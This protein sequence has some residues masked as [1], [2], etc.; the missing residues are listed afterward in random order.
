MFVTFGRFVEDKS[1]YFLLPVISTTLRASCNV[2]RLLEFNPVT[3]ILYG[4]LVVVSGLLESHV[5]R[6]FMETS[7]AETTVMV[8]NL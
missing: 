5:L 6:L 3:L 2:L 1:T 4:L 8:G 7:W